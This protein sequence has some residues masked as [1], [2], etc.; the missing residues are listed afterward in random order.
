MKTA[1]KEAAGVFL[2]SR[3]VIL[4]VSY[5]G[6]TLIP[7]SGHVAAS[8][9]IA[10][11]RPCLLTWYHWD[12]VAYVRI[13]YQGYSSTPDT[14]FFPFWPLLEHIVGFLLGG[15]FP[16]SYYFAGLLLANICFYFVLVLFYRL[17]SEDFEPT[18]AKRALFYLAFYPYAMFFFAGYSESL[19]LLLCLAVFLLLRRGRAYDWWLAGL[20]GFFAALTR[21]S[22]IMLAIPFLVVYIQRFWLPRERDQS[23]WLQKL[24]ALA[25]I[26]LIPAAVLVHMLYLGY[27]KGD[28]LI[29]ISQETTY[30]WHRHLSVPG[31]AFFPAIGTLF[32]QPL[33]TA[34][35]MQNFLDISFTLLPLIA[36]ALSWKR[37]PLHY[38]LFAVAL[39]LFS[40]SF[41]QTV[42]ETLASQPRYMMSIFPVM[43]IFAFWGKRPP[44]DRWFLGISLP[45]LA[46]NVILF[47]SHYW[48]A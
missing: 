39:A 16:D 40:L 29:F 1:L 24:N 26:L 42:A 30:N 37:I 32:T 9:C 36:L 21:S 2:L 4:L 25:P 46:L 15:Y 10:S 13:A 3:L 19:F 48:V 27:T 31:I 11:A 35:M 6:V 33:F 44:F 34:T 17:L 18:L 47:I 43:V 20:L 23:S 8:N 41:P 45:L 7:P 12:A 38:M 14:A 22:G 28:P 5:I